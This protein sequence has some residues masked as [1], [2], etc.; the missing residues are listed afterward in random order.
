MTA[1]NRLVVILVAYACAALVAT[2]PILSLGLLE[3][4][5]LR[6]PNISEF[7]KAV[8]FLCIIAA[9]YSMPIA[10]PVILITEWRKV[11]SWRIFA[12]AGVILGIIL[13][14]LFTEV[15]FR[16]I[17]YRFATTLLLSAS[18]GA[19]AYWFVAWRLFPAR[20]QT[21]LVAE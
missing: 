2:I 19:M 4:N 15:P 20:N 10:V 9:S 7:F 18:A 8:C 6:E 13:S 3:S 1:L 14:V 16:G 11:A 21:E 12:G 17:N 5:A